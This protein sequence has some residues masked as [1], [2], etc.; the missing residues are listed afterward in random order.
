[1]SSSGD[2][3][4]LPTG[5]VYDPFYKEHNTGLGHPECAERLDAIVSA[6]QSANLDKRLLALAPRA[7]T[8]EEIALCHTPDYIALAKNEI[9][10]GEVELSCGDTRVCPLSWKAALLAAGG[11]E[12]A[13]D[14]VVAGTIKNAF[15]AVRPPG[16]HASPN[17]G[18]G[19]CVFN[20]IAIAA[21]YAQRT[22]GIG[23]VA[24]IDWD[25]HHGNGT[26]DTFYEDGSVFYFSTH[27]YPWYPGTGRDVERG[28]G[29]GL[30]CILNC[31]F[32]AG[33]RR[34]EVFKAFTDEFLPAMEKFKPE[35]VL[36]SAGFDGHEADPL[37]GLTLTDEDYAELTGIC[38]KL[39]KD[40]AQGRLVSVLEGG[41]NL[42]TLG[43]TV[44]AHITALTEA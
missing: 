39:A 33:A 16:H 34:A 4:S 37:G 7:A 28:A 12:T 22:H 10:A 2:S 15:C 21:R 17:R 14:A 36:V 23:N 3:A 29:K 6:V 11:V 25:V 27:Q 18:M 13:V 44:A 31:P 42:D 40:Y 20:N 8:V 32:D 43:Q 26:Q 24:I 35:L 5:F 1:M 41:Y 38:V 19:F 9:A 30:G